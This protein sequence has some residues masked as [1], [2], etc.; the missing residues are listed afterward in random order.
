MFPTTKTQAMSYADPETFPD[1]LTIWWKSKQTCHVI[2]EQ[3]KWATVNIEDCL[4]FRK[5]HIL[6]PQ[7]LLFSVI[8]QY[9]PLEKVLEKKS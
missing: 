3:P 8:V 5:F 9:M 6:F 4:W 2:S 1:I 7:H